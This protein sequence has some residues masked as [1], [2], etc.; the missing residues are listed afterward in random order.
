MASLNHGILYSGHVWYILIL[1]R[2]A[3]Y[4]GF[5]ILT[6]VVQEEAETLW[7]VCSSCCGSLGPYEETCAALSET[8]GPAGQSGPMAMNTRLLRLA[9]FIQLYFGLHE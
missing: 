7:I 6:S 3:R 8:N 5:P 4:L 2:L 1:T 9:Q